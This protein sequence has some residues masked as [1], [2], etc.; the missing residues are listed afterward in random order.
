M[1]VKSLPNPAIPKWNKLPQ[2][3]REEYARDMEVYAAMLDYMDMSIGRVIDYLKKDGMYDNTMIVFMSDNGA[4]GAVATTYPGNDDGK[5]LSSFNNHTE[6]RGLQNSYAE[7]G[8]GWAQAST[9]PFRFFKSFA[10]E[11]GIKAPLIIKVPGQM[12]NA[13]QWNKGFAHVTDIMPTVLEI[14]GAS[15]PQQNKGKNVHQPIG[16]SLLPVLKGDSATIHSSDGMGWEL[17]EM[18]AFIKGN[19]KSFDC[20]NPL[21]RVHGNYTNWKKIREKPQIYRLHILMCR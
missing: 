6:N 17:F 21:E 1:D 7:M 16:K 15:Y 20:H 13:G 19:W 18:K 8:P 2:H 9:A 3:V 10:T 4:N 12:K 5:Y 11:G 14:A